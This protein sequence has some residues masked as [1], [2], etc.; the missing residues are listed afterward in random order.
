MIGP[1]AERPLV[2]APATDTLL[3]LIKGGESDRLEFKQ[4]LRFDVETQALNRKLEEVAIKTVAGFAN[5][6]GGTLLIGVR[7]DGVVTGVE[8]DY[9]TLT[10]GNRDKLERASP[11]PPAE[12]ELRHRVPCDPHPHQL[13]RN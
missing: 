8:P 2:S 9:A 10:N 4:T 7:D 11:D 12:S 3:E 6:T 1:G 5:H 13:P